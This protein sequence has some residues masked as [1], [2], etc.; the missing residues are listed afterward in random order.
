MFTSGHRRIRV[1]KQ[2]IVSKRV[3]EVSSLQH[4]SAGS[5]ELVRVS[6]VSSVSY[7]KTIP[8]FFLGTPQSSGNESS[9]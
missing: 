2:I 1:D 4:S 8:A 6:T 7:L 9:S 3:V 5:P